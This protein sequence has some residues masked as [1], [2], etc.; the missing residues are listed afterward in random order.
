[1][2]RSPKREKRPAAGKEKVA[3][4]QKTCILYMHIRIGAIS[5][6]AYSDNSSNNTLTNGR[7]T[8]IKKTTRYYV[9]GVS[10]QFAWRAGAGRRTRDFDR[11]ALGATDTLLSNGDVNIYVVLDS[12][13]FHIYTLGTRFP[14]GMWLT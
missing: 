4:V 2:P 11:V 10:W 13:R 3:D 9:T 7:V 1:M 5:L 14:Y 6:D 12:C 8:R